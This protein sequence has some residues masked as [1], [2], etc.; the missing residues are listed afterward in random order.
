METR[1]P[2]LH[3]LKNAAR[4]LRVPPRWLESQAEAGRLPSLEVDGHRL[5]HVP[6]VE[7][8]MVDL[9]SRLP[10]RDGGPSR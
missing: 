6:A 5:F 9:A 2:Q 8:A 3:R 10:D 1:L 4:L 7:R